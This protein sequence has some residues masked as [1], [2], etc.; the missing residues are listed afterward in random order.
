MS[1]LARKLNPTPESY[2]PKTKPEILKEKINGESFLDSILK[3][4]LSYYN[5]VK[6]ILEKYFGDIHGMAHITGGSIHD[7][8][9]RIIQNDGLQANIDLSAVKMLPV[10]SLIK[11]Y[12]NMT[13]DDMLNNS[14]FNNGVGLIAIVGDNKADVIIDLIKETGI[15]AY[16]IGQINKSDSGNNKKVVLYNELIWDFI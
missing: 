7:N 5:A 10:F 4:H 12:A 6:A 11:K 16:R 15:E 3:P 8:L 1:E 13:D 9:I 2:S 14:P